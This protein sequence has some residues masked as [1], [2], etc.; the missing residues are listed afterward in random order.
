M[1]YRSWKLKQLLKEADPDVVIILE[2]KASWGSILKSKGMLDFIENAGYRFNICYWS[3]RPEREVHGQCGV[4][5]M[6]K[7]TPIRVICGLPDDEEGEHEARVITLEFRHFV[8]VGTYNPQGGFDC[9]FVPNTFLSAVL[10][11]LGQGLR[12][13]PLFS[14]K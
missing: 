3:K 5:V 8:V 7:V 6:S 14:Q 10:L 1:G 9:L 11:F 2:A 12:S 13:W 4:F